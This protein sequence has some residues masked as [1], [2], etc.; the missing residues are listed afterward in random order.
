MKFGLRARLFLVPLTLIA[1]IA[2]ATAWAA[3]TAANRATRRIDDQILGIGKTLNEPPTFPLTEPVLRQLKGLTG[4]DFDFLPGTGPG[5]STLS[6]NDLL[7]RTQRLNR[8]QITI[9]GQDYRWHRF[10]ISLPPNENGT[11]FVYSPESLRRD[12]VRDAIVPPIVLG[13]VGGLIAVSMT[14]WLTGGLLRRIRQLQAHTRAVADDDFRPAIVEGPN[15]ELTELA[16]SVNEMTKRLEDSRKRLQLAERQSI[17]GQ[18][19]GGLAHQLRNAA[20]GAKLA[21]DLYQPGGEREPLDIASRQIDRIGEMVGQFLALGKPAPV[22]K[23]MCD[24]QDIIREV[25]RLHQPQCKHLGIELKEQ[26]PDAPARI[27]ANSSDLNHLITNLISNAIDAT[28][29]N[30]LVIVGLNIC[31]DTIKIEVSDTG[32]GP[33]PELGDRIFEPFITGKH[34]GIGLGLSL[35]KTVVQQ[36]GGSIIWAKE[37]DL[38]VFRVTFP[39]IM[40]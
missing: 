23:V 18:F 29:P 4:A 16:A 25:V 8:P 39:A 35:V 33:P 14:I 38:T 11:L 5:L 30:G 15:D 7:N 21:L 26:I 31:V 3:T 9:H 12:A 17:L 19:S 27:Y 20:G 6:S 37:Q 34:Q 1:V 22:Q 36:H 2:T 28:G 13:V 10:P 32:P 24:L 40:H